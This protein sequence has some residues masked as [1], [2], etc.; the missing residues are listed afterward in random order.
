MTFII[1]LI[2]IF[3]VKIKVKMNGNFISF[4]FEKVLNNLSV[5]SSKI[6]HKIKSLDELVNINVRILNNGIENKNNIPIELIFDEHRVGQV[7]ANFESDDMKDF[8]F[9]AYP[10]RQ[11]I[12][13]AKLV[14]PNDDYLADNFSFIAMPVMEKIKCAIIASNEEE[15]EILKIVL[16]AIDHQISFYLLK[17]DYSPISIDYF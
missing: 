12:V 13:E 8:I 4:T 6:I 2:A 17:P 9:K 7:V 10:G 15:L 5:Y 14:L 1:N 16:S 3:L 11:G